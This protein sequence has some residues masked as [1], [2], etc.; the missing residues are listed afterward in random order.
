MFRQ[1][2]VPGDA[3]HKVLFWGVLGAVVLRGAFIFAGV[4]LANAF[5][6]VLYLFGAI[7]LLAGARMLAG[8][9]RTRSEEG[10]GAILRLLRRLPATEDYR[11]RR[12]TIRIDGKL[13]ATPLLLALIAIELSDIVF[14][15]DSIPAILGVTRDRLVVFS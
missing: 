11:G 14:A 5:E 8:V 3:Q 6:W 2:Q 12:F 13:H 15:L 10:G 7:V 9:V 1:L 4:A